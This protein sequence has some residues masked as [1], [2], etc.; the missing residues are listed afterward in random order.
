[1]A[2]PAILPYQM[3]T[4]SD[5]PKNKVSWTPHPKRAA[6][7]I[8]DMQ[9]YFIDAYNL[10][11]SPMTELFANIKMLKEQCAELG[12]PIIYTAQPGGQ[13]PEE[14]GLLQDFWGSGIG[15]G[16]DGQKIVEKLKPNEGD[17]VLTKWRYNAFRKTNLLG[18]LQ[19]QG[20]D[21]LIVTGVYAHIGCLMTACDAFMQDIETFFVADAV[22][23]FSLKHHEMAISYAADRCAVTVT[24]ENLLNELK[25]GRDSA[26]D[27]GVREDAE[28]LS[29]QIIREQI[30]ALL[31][32][33]PADI[34]D[35]ENLIYRGLDSVRIMSLAE[36][37]RRAGAE[38]TFVELAEE[39]T[40]E[41]WWRLL[42][43]SKETSLPNADYQ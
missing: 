39:P 23:D 13:T 43:S 17:I 35:S 38:V 34:S 25:N 22:A 28:R 6:L 4:A 7:L 40:I 18:I 15:P 27:E 9:Q 8:H 33:S 19:E 11:E 10:G 3:P 2:I 12:I 26:N 32:E 20:R 5:L 24:A 36:R 41:N 14:R 42:S 31:L 30:A 37:W 21:Q 16:P 1:M 29:K